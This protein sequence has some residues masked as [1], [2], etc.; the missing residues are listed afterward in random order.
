MALRTH[1]C[2]LAF[3]KCDLCDVEKSIFQGVNRPCELIF[4]LLAVPK[5]NLGESQKCDIGEVEK[6]MF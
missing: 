2:L 1:F 5:C 6:A 4:Y 3:P